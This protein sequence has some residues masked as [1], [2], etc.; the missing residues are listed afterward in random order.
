MVLDKKA[1]KEVAKL[2]S[3][4]WF[5]QRAQI[6]RDYPGKIM[7]SS[8]EWSPGEH[9]GPISVD[10]SKQS[11]AGFIF[12]QYANGAGNRAVLDLKTPVVVSLHAEDLSITP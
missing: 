1:V 2:T 5:Q 11:K 3:K 9:V 4:D 12:A 7:V 10:V 8:W 6:G